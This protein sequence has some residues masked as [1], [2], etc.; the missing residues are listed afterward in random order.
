[1]NVS[2][3]SKGAISDSMAGGMLRSYGDINY[4]GDLNINAKSSGRYS[5]SMAGGLVISNGEISYNGDLNINAVS[6]GMRSMSLAGGLLISSG[7]LVYNGNTNVNSRAKSRGRGGDAVSVAGLLMLPGINIG[8]YHSDGWIS[9]STLTVNG[10]VFVEA[11]ANARG[12]GS[13]AFALGLGILAAGGDVNINSDSVIVNSIANSKGRRSRATS[14]AGLI[15]F[16]GV[17]AI[18]TFFTGGDFEPANLNVVGNLEANAIANAPRDRRERAIAANVLLAT[19]DITV[20]GAD[21]LASANEALVQGQITMFEV[22]GDDGIG[23]FDGPGVELMA[24]YETWVPKGRANSY[25]QLIIEA[26]GTVDIQPIQQSTITGTGPNEQFAFRPTGRPSGTT[27]D[28]PLRI[29]N[30]GD[31]L[32]ATGFGVTQPPQIR[33]A[34]VGNIDVEA[35]ILAGADPAALLPPTAAGGDA[36]TINNNDTMTTS[37]APDFCDRLVSGAC[38]E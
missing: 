34:E 20:R 30:N 3:K 9:P 37:A 25:A 6:N 21:P 15:T 10:D 13:R 29:T 27:G 31:M 23:C 2:A 7:D 24:L 33:V 11:K 22:C 14:I 26:G 28:Q 17:D 16:A 36:Q 4:T 19:G 38:Y 35:A 1:M 18:E 5:S 32:A 8:G 12:P